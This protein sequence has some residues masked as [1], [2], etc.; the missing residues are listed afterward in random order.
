MTFILKT[1][2]KKPRE[3]L[4]PRGSTTLK[5]LF[6]LRNRLYPLYQDDLLHFD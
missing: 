2:H 6:I 5:Q 3:V 1:N 4:S